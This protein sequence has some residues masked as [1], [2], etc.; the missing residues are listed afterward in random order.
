MKVKGKTKSPK[1]CHCYMYSSQDN[2]LQYLCVCSAILVIL[3]QFILLTP[4]LL[5]MF[6]GKLTLCKRSCLFNCLDIDGAL[7]I[8]CFW[9]SVV[10]TVSW[11]LVTRMH[12]WLLCCWRCTLLSINQ[13]GQYSVG[14]PFTSITADSDDLCI[15]VAETE[16]IQWRESCKGG[17]QE[18]IKQ[19]DG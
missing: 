1:H 14:I 15:S 9:P 6:S 12:S 5:R 16:G 17:K 8:S 7:E 10:C 19:W 11:E 2:T 4:H 13:R 3:N 18:T